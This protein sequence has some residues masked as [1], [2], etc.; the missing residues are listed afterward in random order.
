MNRRRPSKVTAR[1][2]AHPF[3]GVD[4]DLLVPHW[5]HRRHAAA[6]TVMSTEAGAQVMTTEARAKLRQRS[7][8]RDKTH[9]AEAAKALELMNS[10]QQS[11]VTARSHVHQFGGA[12][13]DL[14]APQCR[15]A[16]ERRHTCMTKTRD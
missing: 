12:A 14:L 15:Q 2:R 9:V 3:G 8:A 5:R 7:Q 11:K 1:S 4:D 10:R 13:D 6:M 16:A